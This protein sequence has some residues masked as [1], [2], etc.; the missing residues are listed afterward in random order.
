MP[1]LVSV[2][3]VHA[4]VHH[5]M[6]VMQVAGETQSELIVHE[7][8]VGLDPTPPSVPVPGVDA[9]YD[10]V[11]EEEDTGLHVVFGYGEQSSFVAQLGMHDLPVAVLMHRLGWLTLFAPQLPLDTQGCV[12]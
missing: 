6:P 10:G 5:G 9:Q 8:P 11:G 7:S 1:Q 3:E 2:L 12:Q 4:L